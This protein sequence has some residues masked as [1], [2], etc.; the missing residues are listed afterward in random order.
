MIVWR[1]SVEE[2]HVDM[3][4][5]RHYGN[6][7]HDESW[8]TRND[9]YDFIIQLVVSSDTNDTNDM[10]VLFSS[11]NLLILR[12]RI[13]SNYTLWYNLYLTDL[14]TFTFNEVIRVYQWDNICQYLTKRSTFK[15]SVW[16][17][18]WILMANI[19]RY[20]KS[21]IHDSINFQNFHQT[22]V[23]FMC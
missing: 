11:N 9:L 14:S 16:L 22:N 5:H 23:S 6:N 20:E 1:Y 13:I 17:F 18:L 7:N 8:S 15:H 2:L 19:S 3:H 12:M 4:F 21:E 10:N